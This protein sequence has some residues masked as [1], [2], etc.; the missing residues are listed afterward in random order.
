MGMPSRSMKLYDEYVTG[1]GQRLRVHNR[2]TCKGKHC[3][4]H[5]PSKHPLA[6]APTLWRDDKGIMER[7][8]MHGIGHPDPDGLNHLPKDVQRTMSIHGCDGCCHA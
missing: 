3:V 8:C 2:K 4:I 1:V 5:R 7:I 6:N